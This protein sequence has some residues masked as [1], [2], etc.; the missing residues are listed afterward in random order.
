MVVPAKAGTQLSLVFCSQPR[1]K[2][3]SPLVLKRRAWKIRLIE[4]RNPE[5]KD[6]SDQAF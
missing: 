1:N 6:L 2:N 3:T 4:E 5:W